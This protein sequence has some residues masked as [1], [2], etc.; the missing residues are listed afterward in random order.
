VPLDLHEAVD[1][2]APGEEPHHGG[3]VKATAIQLGQQMMRDV[4]H[5]MPGDAADRPM[6]H[7]FLSACLV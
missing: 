6:V 2:Q 4:V 1:R 7:A 3:F 5:V